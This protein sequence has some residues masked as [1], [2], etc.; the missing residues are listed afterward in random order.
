MGKILERL[1]GRRELIAYM[2][3]GGFV[4]GFFI[5]KIQANEFVQVVA[6]II[7]FYFGQ[8]SVAGMN[9]KV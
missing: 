7:A 6:A 2:V 1:M 3:I 8:R 9:P 4:V 5:G